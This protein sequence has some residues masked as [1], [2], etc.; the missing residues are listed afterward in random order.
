MRL[1]TASEVIS[2]A[3]RLEDES[4]SF[5]KDLSDKYTEDTS[6]FLTL[7]KENEKNITHIERAYYGVISDAIEGCFAFDIDPD[8]YIFTVEL[9]GRENYVEALRKAIGMEEKIAGLYLDA[10]EQSGD[11]LADIPRAFKSIGSMF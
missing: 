1:H 7:A 4:L 5:Y 6:M 9:T 3:K 11:L 8:K 10:A 2:L